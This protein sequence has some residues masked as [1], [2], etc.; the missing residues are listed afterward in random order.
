MLKNLTSKLTKSTKPRPKTILVDMDG[1]IADFELHA[2]NIYKKLRPDWPFIE[3][4]NRRGHRID[5]QY[6]REIGYN[7]AM[8]MLQI[9][10]S[11]G[12]FEFIPPM[13]T[14]LR[15]VKNLYKDDNFKVKICTAPL[16][17][18]ETC[19]QDKLTWLKN[20]FSDNEA[21]QN[22]FTSK[23]NVII[24]SDKTFVK[25]DFLIDDKLVIS[26]FLMDKPAYGQQVLAEYYT[27][28]YVKNHFKEKIEIGEMSEL[29]VPFPILNRDWSNLHEIIGYDTQVDNN[30]SRDH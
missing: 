8:L 17:G 29:D 1:V 7:E 4:K 16:L 19:V 6:Y 18:N 24:T 13:E 3:L 14:A 12:F 25:G 5:N 26:G 21:M 10:H 22:Y 15:N 27:N 23:E 2:L 28:S 11:P 20:N 9:I 30:K